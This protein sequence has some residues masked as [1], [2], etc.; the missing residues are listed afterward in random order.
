ML[1]LLPRLVGFTDSGLNEPYFE[2]LA[3][4][5]PHLV[6]YTEMYKKASEQQI[7]PLPVFHIG[8]GRA[9][10]WPANTTPTATQSVSRLLACCPDLEEVECQRW[11]MRL[12]DI[13][14]APWVCEKL[15]GFNCV[16]TTMPL[17][18]PSEQMMYRALLTRYQ[19]LST[20]DEMIMPSDLYGLD[21]TQVERAVLDKASLLARYLVAIEDQLRRLPVLD[22]N[23]SYDI[24]DVSLARHLALAKA[25]I[26]PE[27]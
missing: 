5:C 15:K 4:H 19:K 7:I 13:T 26:W 25:S 17:L 27:C 1:P 11:P 12:E 24:S 20:V 8:N 9:Q 22:M 2:Q 16:F 10:H 14:N 3:K 18:S 23:T 21:T 6:Y